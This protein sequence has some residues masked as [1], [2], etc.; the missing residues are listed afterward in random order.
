MN[1][2][3]SDVKKGCVKAR[4]LTGTYLLQ[5][6]WNKFTNGKESSLC[7][8]CQIENEDIAHFLLSCVAL[9]SKRKELYQRIIDE[10]IRLIGRK[11]W[12]LSFTDKHL[13]VKVI[14]DCSFLKKF[15]TTRN[16]DSLEH[17]H[18]LTTDFCYK[19][20][21]HRLWILSNERK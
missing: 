2:S 16:L 4:L 9:H 13:I 18:K 11:Q 12:L 19:L 10:I 6:L 15:I 1:S 3:V 14:I 17:L 5:T 20:H 21:A 8:C 7:K